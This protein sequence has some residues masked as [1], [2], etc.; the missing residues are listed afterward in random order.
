MRLSKIGGSGQWSSNAERDLL[1]IVQSDLDM[2]APV[3]HVKT[4]KRGKDGLA[5][6][7]DHAVILPHE[8]FSAIWH[9]DAA[10]FARVFMVSKVRC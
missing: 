10:F 8:L 3:S 4:M 7:T 6:E 2:K 1:H 9:F 5:H